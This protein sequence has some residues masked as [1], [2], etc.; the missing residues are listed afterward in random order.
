MSFVVNLYNELGLI[1]T[2]CKQFK[3]SADCYKLALE[4][5]EERDYDPITPVKKAALLQ[6][7]G[8]VCNSFGNYEQAA[9]YSR[10]ASYIYGQSWKG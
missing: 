3:K 5:C 9:E 10:R 4:A 2:Q 1:L 6:N 7:L 8:A